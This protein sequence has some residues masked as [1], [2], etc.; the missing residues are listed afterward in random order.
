MTRCVRSSAA[1]TAIDT[2]AREKD[3]DVV[4]GSDVEDG[5]S[6]VSTKRVL[7]Y[8]RDQ[9]ERIAGE[10]ERFCDFANPDAVSENDMTDWEER[11]PREGWLPSQNLLFNK[12]VQVLNHDRLARLAVKGLHRSGH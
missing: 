10:V 8:E 5:E 6:A 2:R 3:I 11:V 1:Q 4:G 7:P 9:V 12:T